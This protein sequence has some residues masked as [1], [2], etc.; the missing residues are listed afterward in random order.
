M[1]P[2]VALAIDHW[3][4]AQRVL[5][6][7][8]G[9]NP[10]YYAAGD[11]GAD[12]AVI[13]AQVEEG[14]TRLL[15]T[16]PEACVSG[17]LRG[18]LHSAAARGWLDSL[19][20]DE[21]HLVD[22]WGME[23]RADYQVLSALRR[24]W[25]SVPDSRVRTLLLSATFTPECRELLRVLFGEDGEDW[26]EFVSQR[27]R[28]ELTYYVQRFNQRPDR[29]RALLDCMWHLP[30]PTLV[31]TTEV[32]EARRIAEVLKD[33]GF[34]DVG[35]FHGETRAD[36]R[37]ALLD[38]WRRD[39]LDVVVATSAFG[40]GVDKHDVRSVVH[41]CFPQDLHR[42]YQEVGRGGRD[43]YSA[44]CVLLPTAHDERVAEELAPILLRERK[45]QGRWNGL[46][47]TRR[48]SSAEHVWHIRLD[49]KP[50]YLAGSRTGKQ[51]INWNKRLLLQLVRARLLEL[52]DVRL[53]G[54]SG[55]VGQCRR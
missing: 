44:I 17:R 36:R 46:W 48:A 8:P 49:A 28:P 34:N 4:N 52:R 37:R 39:E 19:V 42:Y 33:E 47:A 40:L 22:T 41:A 9:V 6:K 15:F 13:L 16:S 50:I 5:E 2:T 18:A 27:L 25:L 54:S 24:Q 7:V 31:Y 38:R 30:R 26:R 45:I 43:G 51:H 1:V 23:F 35:C 10:L 11:P 32:D 53:G 12:P 14:A 55:A 3:R 20:I 21:A 29:D